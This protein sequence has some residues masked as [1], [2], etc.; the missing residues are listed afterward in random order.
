MI[1]RSRV[2]ISPGAR[3]CVLEQDT[4]SGRVVAQCR[5]ERAGD[6]SIPPPCCFL[7]QVTL[8]PESTGNTQEA[9]APSRHD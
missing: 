7:E 4:S 5:S 3:C 8:F 1:A 6:R 2:R 9:V